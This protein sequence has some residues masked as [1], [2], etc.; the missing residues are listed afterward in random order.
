MKKP[1]D[2]LLLLDRLESLG[3]T[4]S[5][6]ALLHHFRSKGRDEPIS[7]HRSHCE[8]TN[9]FQDDGNNE[10]VQLRLKLVLSAY[11]LG[12]FKKTDP[13]IF[14]CLAEAAYLEIQ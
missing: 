14:E 1:K 3:F 12:G 8:I 11:L 13:K 9:E 7:K 4:D 10:K 2:T 6:F 5:A